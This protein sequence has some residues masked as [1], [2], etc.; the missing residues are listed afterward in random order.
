MRFSFR[1]RYRLLW[2]ALLVAANPKSAEAT[3]PWRNEGSNK[4]I[5]HSFFA[6]DLKGIQL[7]MDLFSEIAGKSDSIDSLNQR[8]VSLM[9]EATKVFCEHNK[10]DPDAVLIHARIAVFKADV[11]AASKAPT[12]TYKAN[13]T[14]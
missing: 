13:P 6:K 1:D 10:L 5:P 11:E 14:E 12:V 7:V 8:G 2:R 3:F 9:L 4:V